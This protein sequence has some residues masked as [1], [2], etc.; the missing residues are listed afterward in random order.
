[1]RNLFVI[2][3][4]YLVDLSSHSNNSAYFYRFS[5]IFAM[6]SNMITLSC[7]AAKNRSCKIQSNLMIKHNLSLTS[8]SSLC[9]EEIMLLTQVV[10]SLNRV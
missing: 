10:S 4:K 9:G 2:K 5:V 3:L 1:M 7:A 6:A 8:F